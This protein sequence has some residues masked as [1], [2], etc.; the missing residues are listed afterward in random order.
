MRNRSRWL[1]LLVVVWWTLSG[2]VSAMQLM[3]MS[4]IEGVGLSLP[5][6]LAI[7]LASSALWIPITLVLFRWVHRFPIEIDRFASGVLMQGAAVVGVIVFRAAAVAL[8]NP[9]VGWYAQLPDPGALLWTSLWNNFFTSWLIIGVGHALVYAERAAERE[10]R[11]VEL[12]ASLDQARLQSLTAQINPHFLFNTLNSVAELLHHN[13]AAADRALVALGEL[14][15]ESLADH[16]RTTTLAREIDLVE[17]YLYIESLRLQE[18]LVVDWSVDPAVLG[19]EVPTLALQPLV[20]NAIRHAIAPRLKPGHIWISAAL[21]SEGRLRIN[22]RDDGEVVTPDTHGE[23]RTG[24]IGL[25]NTRSRLRCLY[26]DEASLTF[27]AHRDGG[28]SADIVI[29]FIS[30]HE[31]HHATDAHAHCR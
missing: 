15:R 1:V 19:C 18:R 7:N 30:R 27:A 22:V 29:P 12:R 11:N 14:L 8:L 23:R 17:R 6:A 26:G 16:Q 24:G 2:L 3:Q 9:V 28:A 31:D 5:H 13:A 21:Q 20:E 10:R 4:E 25:E